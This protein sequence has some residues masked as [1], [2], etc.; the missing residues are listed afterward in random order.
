MKNAIILHGTGTLNSDFWFPYIKENLKVKGYEVWLPQLP[1]ADV[2]NLEEWLPFVLRQGKF[3]EETVIIGHS[4]GSQLILNIL[5]KIDVKIKKAILVSG[6]AESLRESEISENKPELDWEGIKEHAE[7]FI[8]INSDND[9]W[10]CN[11]KQGKIMQD[12]LGG[13]LIILKGEG[14]MG[15]ATYNQPYKEFPLIA[16]LI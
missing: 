16:E 13:K 9:P 5:E 11:D 6:Y 14:H 4:A 12:K 10:G 1:N 8:F 15:S 3:L 2:P 7:E